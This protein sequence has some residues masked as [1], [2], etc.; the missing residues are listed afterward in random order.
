MAGMIGVSV[1]VLDVSIYN[2]FLYGSINHLLAILLTLVGI[3]LILLLSN[4]SKRLNFLVIIVFY[5]SVFYFHFITLFMLIPVLW[6][7]RINQTSRQHWLF[8][9]A[10]PISLLIA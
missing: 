6:F 1:A 3:V 10:F 5:V 4:S 8:I 9:A 2:N 7:L